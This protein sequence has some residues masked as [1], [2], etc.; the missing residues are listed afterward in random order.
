MNMDTFICNPAF[1]L[2]VIEQT[3]FDTLKQIAAISNYVVR[4]AGGWVRDKA[5]IIIFF[6]L[7]N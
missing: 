4:V 6:D 7:I 2:T 3:I 1:E 5:Y